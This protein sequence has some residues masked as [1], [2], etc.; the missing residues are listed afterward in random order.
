MIDVSNDFK[1]RT[2]KIKQQNIKLSI[3]DGELTV[4]DVH[5]MTVKQFNSM[6]VWMLRA[7]KKVA[8][9]E[10]RYSFE[11]NLFK[12]IMKQIEIT[13]KNARE[14]KDKNVNFKYGI[15]INNKFE[16]IDLGDYYIKDVDDDKGKQELVVTGYDK[17]INFMKTFKQ[18]ELQ[19][20]YPCTML[21]LIQKICKVCGVELYSTNF[22]NANL[23][24][25]EDY[26]TAQELTYR[27]VLEKVAESTETTI[28]IKDDKLYLHKLTNNP[29]EKL[30]ASYLTELTIKEKFG[31]VNALVLGRGDVEDNIEA[32][33]DESIAQNGRCEIRFDENEFVEYQREQV[34]DEMFEQIKGL[35]YYAFEGS[36]VGVMWL[37]PCDLIEVEDTEKSIYKTIY[38]SANVTINTGISSDIEAEIPEET[39]TEYK[40]ASKEEKKTLKVERL[41]KKNEGLIQD[42]IEETTE[43]TKKLSKHEQTIDRI[44]D[45]LSSIEIQIGKTVKSVEVQYALSNSFEEAPTTGWTTVAPEWQEGKYMW[46]K[47]V[48]IYTDGTEEESEPTCI[49]GAKGKDGTDGKDGVNGKDG[50]DGKDGLGIKAIE[51]Q[52][53]LSTSNTTLSGGSWKNTQDKWTKGK[54]IWTRSEITWEDDTVTYSE[55]IVAEGLNTANENAND[56]NEGTKEVTT[57]MSKVER[58]VESITDTVSEVE[59]KVTT[60]ESTANQ[61][62]DTAEETNNNLTNN[63]YTKTETNSQIQQKADSITSEVSKTYST[64]TE[65]TNAKNEAINKANKNTNQKLEDYTVTEELGTVIEQNW[66]HVK[67]AWNQISEFIQMMIINESASLAILDQSGNVIMSL[68]KEGQNFYKAGETT[69]PFGEMGIKKIDNQN[70]ISFSVL[71]NYGESIQDGMAWGITIKEDG[72]FLPILYIKD[73]Q[74]AEKNSEYGKGNLVLSACDILLDAMGGGIIA[75]GLKI[76]GGPMPGIWF[77]DVDNGKTIMSIQLESLDNGKPVITILDSISFYANTAGGN[78]LKIGNDNTRYCLMTDNGELHAHDIYL[79]GNNDGKTI[80]VTGQATFSDLP[81]YQG[82]ALVYGEGHHYHLEWTGSQ[83]VFFVDTTNVGTLSDKRLKAEITEIDEDFINAIEEIEMKQFKVA[84]RNGLI[85]FGILAQD[86]IEIFKKYNKNPFDYEI[87]FKTKYK[88]DD[89][90]IYY[91]IDYTQFLILKQKAIDLKVRM[92]KEENIRKDEMLQ[93]SIKRV[94]KLE[95][96]CK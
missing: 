1:I 46:Q 67:V 13:V 72:K 17:M 62:K 12:T 83:L 3:L 71:G 86:L 18:S 47:T 34:I 25:A 60:V 16:Y 40:V 36:D 52:Y 20:T 45:T 80:N 89:D 19:L 54:Y 65:T 15:Y 78:S 33:D 10:L 74:V 92:L 91:A 82:D 50:T 88:T 66:E 11:G 24:V 44:T 64:K 7:R 27:D 5:F 8:A 77:E 37:E 73:F 81:T 26:F 57:K 30:D 90:T 14:L 85:S 69:N 75:D 93:N 38:L 4:K 84:N 35:E 55:P 70:Y 96:G 28:F 48:T 56:A 95:G 49:Q 9:K 94:E 63:Y 61:A 31:P 42:V 87:V 32:K 6:P 2:K 68:D 22:F 51:T 53:Y 23:N 29:V 76:R 59:E 79:T 41:A 58:T 39:N 43:N 21:E